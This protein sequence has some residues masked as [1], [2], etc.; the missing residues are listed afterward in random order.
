MNSVL[1]T[2]VICVAM[3]F[4]IQSWAHDGKASLVMEE[5]V[6]FHDLLVKE[7]PGKIDTKTIVELLS[8][9]ADGKKD[10]ETFKKAIPLAEKLGMAGNLQDKRNAYSQLVDQLESIV[11]HHDKSQANLFFCPMAK[12]KWIAKGEQIVNP[13]LKDMRDCGEKQ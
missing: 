3:F 10:T 13:Y 4:S 9:G 5:M 2:L 12:K 6:K 11:G 7:A 8:K 1:K